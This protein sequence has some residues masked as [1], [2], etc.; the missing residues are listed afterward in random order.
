MICAASVGMSET[1]LKNKL[2]LHTQ[3]KGSMGNRGRASYS[4]AEKSE[5]LALAPSGT[6]TD[7]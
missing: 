7:L 1:G 4:S 3:E 5:D 6:Q 2:L